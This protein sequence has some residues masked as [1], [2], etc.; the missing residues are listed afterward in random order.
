MPERRFRMTLEPRNIIADS[1]PQPIEVCPEGIPVELKKRPQWSNWKYT[2]NGK[3]WTK[4]PYDPR[5]GRKS[6]STYLMTWRGFEE[7][8]AA[9]KI[10]KYDGIG[11]AFCSA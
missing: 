10:R 8:C 6:S 2:W 5:P 3:K 1:P 9:L 7:A 11:F 4:H